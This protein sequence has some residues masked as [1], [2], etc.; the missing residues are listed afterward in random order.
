MDEQ[1]TPKQGRPPMDLAAIV[2]DQQTTIE[3]L[4]KWQQQ[5]MV[6]LG[7]MREHLGRLE[8]QMSARLR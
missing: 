4:Q 6:D 3:Q 7:A 2:E 5:T 1:V 8:A